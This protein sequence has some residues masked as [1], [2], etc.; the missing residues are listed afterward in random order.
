MAPGRC[1]VATVAASSETH[2]T[3]RVSPFRASASPR[4]PRLPPRRPLGGA[5]LA[6]LALEPGAGAV[7][8][9]PG[10]ELK[11]GVQHVAVALFQLKQPGGREQVTLRGRQVPPPESRSPCCHGPGGP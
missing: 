3:L 5:S 2:Q 8:G 4:P 9:H 11:H 6:A 1:A 10:Q 7:P